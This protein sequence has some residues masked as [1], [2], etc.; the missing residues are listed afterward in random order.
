MG[1]KGLLPAISD[2]FQ[3]KHLR[4]FAHKT[5]AIDGYSWLHKGCF[6][7]SLDLARGA[8]TDGYIRYF[9]NRI[10]QL[11][12][13]HVVPFV[14]FDGGNLPSKAGTEEERK[15]RREEARRKGEAYMNK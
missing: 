7:C 11:L 10:R 2:T 8:P 3:K 9:M 13:S 15:N 4:E 5:A 12:E 1:I 14:V 6:T